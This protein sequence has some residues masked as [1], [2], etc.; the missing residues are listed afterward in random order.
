MPRKLIDVSDVWLER[1]QGG[2]VQTVDTLDGLR[3]Q[4]ETATPATLQAALATMRNIAQQLDDLKRNV[5]SWRLI[6]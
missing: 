3:L 2:V 6:F 4:L 5:E 1:Y